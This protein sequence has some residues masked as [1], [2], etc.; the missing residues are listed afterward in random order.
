[1]DDYASRAYK[2]GKQ[3]KDDPVVERYKDCIED[4]K[5]IMPLVEEVGQA[6]FFT[7]DQVPLPVGVTPT[8][9]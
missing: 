2:M 4:F 1:M 6:C 7:R 5:Q 8:V 9:G 3:Y